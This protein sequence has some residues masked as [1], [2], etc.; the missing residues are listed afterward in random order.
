MWAHE[1]K[2]KITQANRLTTREIGRTRTQ[3]VNKSEVRRDTM[4]EN[5]K[6]M[7]MTR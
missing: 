4:D 6:R 3:H 1:G 5:G 7:M 2:E